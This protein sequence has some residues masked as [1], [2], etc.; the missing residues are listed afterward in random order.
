MLWN[1]KSEIPAADRWTIGW[2]LLSLL[3]PS[4]VWSGGHHLYAWPMGLL[5]ALAA[6]ALV[7]RPLL[8]RMAP[9]ERSACWRGLARDPV[10]WVGGA[11][12]LLLFVRWRNAWWPLKI[13]EG[14]ASEWFTGQ[15]AVAWLPWAVTSSEAGILAFGYF[16]ALVLA[17]LA[18]HGLQSRRAIRHLFGAL[19]V[20]ASLLAAFGLV[21]YVSGT[22]AL[23][24]TVPC[25]RHFFASFYYENHAG[26][27]FYLM[28]GLAVG[29]T[30]YYL[31]AHPRRPSRRFLVAMGTVLA[32]TYLAGVFSLSRMAIVFVT[33]L[34]VLGAWY[35]VRHAPAYLT[36]LSRLHMIT[37]LAAICILG[38]VLVSGTLG[39]DIRDDFARS[40]PGQNLIEQ[41]LQARSW[42]WEAAGRIW[43]QHPVL[44]V[45]SY[46]FRY[47]LP[48]Y[49]PG[50]KLS[51]LAQE[52]AGQVHNDLLNFLCE[53]GL[54]GTALALALLF[55]LLR[56]AWRTGAGQRELLRFPLLAAVL[57]LLHSLIDLPFL[58]PAVFGAWFLLVA[59][60]GRY[61]ELR[62]S[63]GEAAGPAPPAAP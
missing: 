40:R 45:G 6:L 3:Y 35:L 12:V 50:G 9:D 13:E 56:P 48:F 10:L 27:Y 39:E 42:Q 8:F 49:T 24:W 61:A 1:S 58:S 34:F 28:F 51:Q 18:R 31:C 11:F 46:G 38:L 62:S 25:T 4:W 2:I 26:Q 37:G 29:Y 19:L 59:A 63:G 21:Q 16:N 47:F 36:P 30:L 14:A 44:G 54:V 20:N 57:V 17:L 43:L 15:P 7:A 53:Q 22:D 60:C 55:L 23:Y 33:L 52:H 5:A 32:L 41:A